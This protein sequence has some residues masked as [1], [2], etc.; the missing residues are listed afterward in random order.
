MD[1][2]VLRGRVANEIWAS[3]AYQLVVS[4]FRAMRPRIPNWNPE[5]DNVEQIK[6]ALAQR[7]WHDCLAVIFDLKPIGELPNE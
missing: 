3:P 5:K 2:K 7:E 6:K 1:K 4:E